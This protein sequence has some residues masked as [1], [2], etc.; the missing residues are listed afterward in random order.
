MI[1][2]LVAEDLDL[3]VSS[4]QRFVAAVVVAVCVDLD[5]QRKTL[6]PL[7]RGK[8]CAQTVHRDEDL[9][10]S[11][12]RRKQIY[13]E[14]NGKK[15]GIHDAHILDSVRKVLSPLHFLNQKGLK[16]KEPSVRA[17][18]FAKMNLS[19]LLCDYFCVH[20]LMCC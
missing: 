8:V 11:Q 9:Q 3:R 17:E 10:G 15:K 13:K 7:L 14:G 18:R 19:K 1:S 20:K 6:H 2:H 4:V 16:K 12:R 5:H